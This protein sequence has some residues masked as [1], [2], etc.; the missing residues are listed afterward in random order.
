MCPSA[1][2]T[3]MPFAV[4]SVLSAHMAERAAGLMR[5]GERPGE[6]VLAERASILPLFG[7]ML[8]A[9]F[10]TLFEKTILATVPA[11]RQVDE[12]GGLV[13][14]L[15][16]GNG[17]YLRALGRAFPHVRGVGVDGFSENVEQATRLARA[18]GLH[19]RLRFEQ[20]D[21][22]GYGFPEPADLITM[23]RALH[24]VWEGGSHKVFEFFREHLKDGGAAVVW[25]PNWP[26]DRTKLREGRMRGLSFQNLSEHIQG[27]HLL[28]A[29]EIASAFSDHG[30]D[31]KVYLFGEGA[32]AI[33]VGR[34]RNT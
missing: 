32:E 2:D 19:E 25:E 6:Q 14:D 16:C 5:S 24:H 8:E 29:D 17:W 3:L 1:P 18:D 13:V 10:R 7:P 9:N 22:L 23:N 4:Q 27:N 12:H 15:G 21:L 31:A 28:G 26:A 34:K 11:F 30:M 33:I 20:G